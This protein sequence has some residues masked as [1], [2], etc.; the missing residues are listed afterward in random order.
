MSGENRII[1]TALL[2][3]G[4]GM[5]ASYTAGIV[6]TLLEKQLYFDYVAGISAGSS[7]AVNYLAR[8]SWRAKTSFVDLVQDPRFGG[9]ISF[10]QGKGY[11]NA[12]YIYEKTPCPGGALPLDF[13]K[14]QA[15]GARV[16]IGAMDRDRG[17]LHYFTEQDIREISDLAKIVRASSSMPVFMPPTEFRGKVYVDGGLGGGIPLDIGLKDGLTRFFAVLTREKGYR[18]DPMKYTGMMKLWYRQYPEVV[19]AMMNRHRRYNETLDQLEQLESEGR[20]FLVYPDRMPVS[21]RETDLKKLRES[22]EA[23]YGQ[24]QRDVNK[25]VDFL[26]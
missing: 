2:F 11:F 25:W 24:G 10:L 17:E 5:R 6:N 7:H 15:C 16:R 4:G 14:F 1:D 23:G 26:L 20:A 21:S 18:K 8:D 19:E 12:E 13:D 3:E 22:Y 9:W